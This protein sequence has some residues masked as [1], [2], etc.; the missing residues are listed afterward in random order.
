MEERLGKAARWQGEDIHE[1][2]GRNGGRGWRL[3]VD[4]MTMDVLVCATDVPCPYTGHPDELPGEVW[5]DGERWVS[6]FVA[7][8]TLYAIGWHDK[9]FE[10]DEDVCCARIQAMD[11][12]RK[13]GERVSELVRSAQQ[14]YEQAVR[15]LHETR[16]R[17]GLEPPGPPPKDL[18][19]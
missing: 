5:L 11:W 1:Y 2:D 14:Q 8:V 16:Q 10:L 18:P 13:E 4:Q 12:L 15:G 17:L 6:E 19:S 7:F 9:L 3:K